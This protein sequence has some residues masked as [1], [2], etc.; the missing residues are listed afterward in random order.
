MIAREDAPGDKRLVAYVVPEGGEAVAEDRVL[1]A[2]LRAFVGQRLPDYMV[3][4]AVVVLDELPLSVNGK[5]DRSALPAPETAAPGEGRGPVTV[6]EEI[7]CQAFAEVLGVERV[8]AEDNFFE[9]GGHSLLAVSL[10]QRLRERG[11]G[12]SVR[13]LF[14]SPTPAALAVAGAG[15]EV[16]VPPNGIPDGA[17]V[18]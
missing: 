4:S 14:E 16:E 11:L 3:P 6:A 9:L 12:V 10:V 15:A 18:I 8:G 5:V 1:P 2:D 7:V 13:V 17:K